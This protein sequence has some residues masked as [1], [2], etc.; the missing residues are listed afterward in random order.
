MHL[1]EIGLDVLHN[2]SVGVLLLIEIIRGK[3]QHVESSRFVLIR[4]DC[5]LLVVGLS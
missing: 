5:Q 1:R 3:S 4:E 2:F